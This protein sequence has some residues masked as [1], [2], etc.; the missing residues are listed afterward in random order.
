MNFTEQ[1]GPLA[2]GIALGLEQNMFSN[3]NSDYLTDG[4]APTRA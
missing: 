4:G 3:V 2:V 1:L